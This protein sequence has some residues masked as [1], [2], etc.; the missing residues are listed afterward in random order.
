MTTRSSIGVLVFLL[1]GIG[2]ARLLPSGENTR[3]SQWST[4]EEAAANFERIIPYKTTVPELKALGYDPFTAPN[5]KILTYLDVQQRFLTSPA[6][7]REDLPPSISEALEAKGGCTAYEIDASV[8]RSRRYG[9]LFL[10]MMTFRRQTHATGWNF[11]A[12]I[13]IKDQM[14]IYKLWS[15]EPSV[16]ETEKTRSPLGPLQSIGGALKSVL[17]PF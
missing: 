13:V 8:K 3:T 9:N 11:K 7:R 2:C 10:D 5:I 14:V 15:G 6:V 12:L 1:W 17:W 16:D 4:Y